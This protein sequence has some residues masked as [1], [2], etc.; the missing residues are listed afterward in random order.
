MTQTHSSGLTVEQAQ[1]LIRREIST[2]TR[3]RYL[4]F[5]MI[6]LLGVGL[7]S[8]LWL[9]EPMPL[10]FRTQ[11]AF[12]GLVL[13]NLAWSAFFGWVLMQRKVLYAVHSVVA[14]WM[15]V[16][17]SST[18]I[19]AGLTI[20]LVRMNIAALAA[21]GV[22]GAIQLM[23]AILMLQRARHRRRGLLGRRD[24]LSRALAHGGL[25]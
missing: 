22:V 6:A 19:V 3:V 20:G 2:P 1:E 12:G 15:A 23:A 4:M 25:S 9:T 16:V 14:G 21:V 11:A 13:I 5:L 24:E 8:T 7:I 18:F 17:F 10:P